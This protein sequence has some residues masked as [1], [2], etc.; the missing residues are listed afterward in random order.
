MKLFFIC[1]CLMLFVVSSCRNH[2]TSQTSPVV[3]YEKIRQDLKVILK[4]DQEDRLKLRPLEK[5]YGYH[6]EQVKAVWRRIKKKDANNLK[7]VTA[8]LDKYGWLGT[9]YIG[10]G[11]ACL[12]F[13]IQHAD[14]NTQKKY[15]PMMREAAKI[16]NA[17]KSNLALLEDRILMRNGKKQLYGSQISRDEKSD[18]WVVYPISDPEK[19]D[20]RRE[21]MGLPTLSEYVRHWDIEWNIQKHK[22]QNFVPLKE[23]R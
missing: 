2:Q 16:G 10:E 9:E 3:D 5:K 20:E 12:F 18:Q 11:N 8:I 14:F 7:K 4:A 13:V 6:S 15:L 1:C 17:R 23:A 19:V 21:E 22:L